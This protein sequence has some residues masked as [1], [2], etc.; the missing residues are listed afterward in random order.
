MVPALMVSIDMINHDARWSTEQTCLRYVWRLFAERGTTK[1]KGFG[2]VAV[3]AGL[4]GGEE[5][6]GRHW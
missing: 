3:Q 4:N 2:Y 1:R 6:Y 5:I